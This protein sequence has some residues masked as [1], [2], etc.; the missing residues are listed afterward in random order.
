VRSAPLRVSF[1]ADSAGLAIEGT[2]IAFI[3]IKGGSWVERLSFCR[4]R[5]GA[6]GTYSW[7]SSK[8]YSYVKGDEIPLSVVDTFW[9]EGVTCLLNC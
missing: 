3:A 4:R 6:K 5:G 7:S 9:T 2:R 8:G 1:S